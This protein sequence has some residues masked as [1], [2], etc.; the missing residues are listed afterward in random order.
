MAFIVRRLCRI[1][2]TVAMPALLALLALS[3]A[4][5]LHPVTV[6]SAS[7][8][9]TARTPGPLPAVA[10]TRHQIEQYDETLKFE[11]RAGAITL[12]EDRGE[13]RAEIGFVAYLLNDEMDE[14]EGARGAARPVTFAVNGGPGAASAYLHI[15]ALGPWRLPM[16]GE[17]ISPSQGIAL[18]DNAE[19]WL[20]FTDLVFVDP[21]GTG[22]SRLVENDQD[23]REEFLSVEGDIA[24]LA[25]FILDWLVLHGRVDSPVYFVGESYGGFRGPLLAE[26]LQSENGIAL[27]GMTLVSPVLDFGWRDSSAYAPLSHVSLLPSLAAAAAARERDGAVSRD[28]LAAVEAYATGEFLADMLRGLG[29]DEA[30]ARLIENVAHHTGLDEALVARFKGRIDMRTFVREIERENGRI[31]SLY[32]AGVTADHPAPEAAFAR[33]SDPVL[34]ALTPPLTRAML[35]LYREKLA[36]MPQRRYVLLNDDVNRAW[37]WGGGRGQPEALGAL[38]RV[39]AL[40]EFFDVLVVHGLTDLVT[41]YFETALLLRQLRPFT[42]EERLRLRTYGGGHMFYDRETSRRAFREDAKRLYRVPEA[43]R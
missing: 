30:V 37:N 23:R 38:R 24:A 16:S 4:A 19:T 15:G 26:R 17:A 31:A 12:A 28:D 25:D 33:A 39:M 43:A 7:E 42:G 40:D 34:D 3:W 2:H 13:E 10:I 35:G 20:D 22:F 36:W 1:R 9:M 11:A 41:P 21:V 6:L 18:E 14:G 29:D 32:D 27:S 5:G 8:A